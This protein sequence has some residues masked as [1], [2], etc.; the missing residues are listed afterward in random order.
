MSCNFIGI[1]IWERY[2]L[3]ARVDEVISRIVVSELVVGG[4]FT[5]SGLIGVAVI[6]IEHAGGRVVS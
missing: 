3:D 2:L 5:Q 6:D 4:V 1:Y